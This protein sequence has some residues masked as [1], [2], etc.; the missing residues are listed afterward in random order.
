MRDC[1][2]T[3]LSEEEGHRCACTIQEMNTLIIQSVQTAITPSCSLTPAPGCRVTGRTHSVKKRNVQMWQTA[4]PSEHVWHSTAD[5]GYP[6]TTVW[7]S[8]NSRPHTSQRSRRTALGSQNWLKSHSSSSVSRSCWSNKLNSL[9]FPSSSSRATSTHS[10]Q[11]CFFIN[12][13]V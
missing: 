12:P 13:E 6:R 10:N 3:P 4:Y 11:G 1:R 2:E 7:S 5:G 9:Q 8:S